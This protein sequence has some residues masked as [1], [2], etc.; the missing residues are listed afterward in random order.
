LKYFCSLGIKII[1]VFFLC[2]S[3]VRA[4]G[5]SVRAQFAQY[6][7]TLKNSP[8]NM[9]V[10]PGEEY[11]IKFVYVL[12]GI[13]LLV[14][15]KFKNWLKVID[16]DGDVGWMF[17]SFLYSPNMYV[18]LTQDSELY[19]KA[20]HRSS[21]IAHVKKNVIVT[22]VTLENSYAFVKHGSGLSG[23]LPSNVLFGIPK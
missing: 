18:I 23:W 1:A 9:R 2:F 12:K 19:A 11:K 13:P 16:S 7:A 20:D 8:V 14:V 6:F 3:G 5:E 21:V 10:G 17:K 15:A 22:F 4:S